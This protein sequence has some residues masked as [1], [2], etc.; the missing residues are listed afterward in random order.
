MPQSIRKPK[1]EP[2]GDLRTDRGACENRESQRGTLEGVCI[3]HDIRGKMLGYIE[4]CFETG[5]NGAS[6]KLHSVLVRQKSNHFLKKV[7]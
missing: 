1:G 2:T 5:L 6:K 3:L 4:E 7:R